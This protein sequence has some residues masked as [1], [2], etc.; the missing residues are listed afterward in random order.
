MN[1]LEFI[2]DI[3]GVASKDIRDGCVLDFGHQR[4]YV[5]DGDHCQECWEIEDKRGSNNED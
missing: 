4:H 1:R 5:C 2:V 3:T